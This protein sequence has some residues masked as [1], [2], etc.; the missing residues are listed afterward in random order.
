MEV[1]MEERLNIAFFVSEFAPLCKTGGLADVAGALPEALAAEGHSVTL[2]CPFYSEIANNLKKL[3]LTAEPVIQTLPLWLGNRH[4]IVGVHRVRVGGFDAMLIKSDELYDRPAL[5]QQEGRDYSDNLLRFSAFVQAS[6]EAILLLGLRFDVFHSHDWQAA[7]V[8]VL[9][10]Y[11]YKVPGI[12]NIPHVL[13]I[14]NLGYQGI[15]QPAEYDYMNLPPRAFNVECLEYYN[16]INLLKGGI[17]CADAVTTVSPTYAREILT[18]EFGAGLDGVL[19]SQVSKLSGILNGI[20]DRVWNPAIDQL[21]PM[22]YSKDTLS[23]K[24]DRKEA[25]L[26][27]VGLPN[28]L[29][30]PLI[31]MI[32]RLAEQK[33]LDLVVQAAARLFERNLALVILGTGDPQLQQAFAALAEAY[34]DKLKVIL[35]FDD[36]LAH[37]IEAGADMFLMPSRYEPCGLNQLYSMRYGTIPI[38]NPVGGLRDSVIP[39]TP[40]NAADGTARGFWLNRL[41][42]EGLIDAVDDALQVYDDAAEWE[43]LVRYDMGLDFS[44][45]HSARVYEAL[46]RQLLG[47]K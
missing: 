2:F 45:V 31:G 38:V 9:S 37:R 25:L 41:S 42:L 12:V 29:G 7:L 47:D 3:H 15:F 16:Q 4:E 5:Y 18:E 40:E 44:W 17:Y 20:D 23:G 19:R 11:R 43:R 30:R 1:G 21:L 36:G 13:T 39:Y 46:Y 10:R 33:G 8:P 24:K 28:D 32:T 6:L 26:N 22:Q 27:E 35:K 34:P 14:H